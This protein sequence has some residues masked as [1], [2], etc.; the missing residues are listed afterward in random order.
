M[1]VLP[2]GK[3]IVPDVFWVHDLHT[4][5]SLIELTPLPFMESEYIKQIV[6]VSELRLY[7]FLILKPQS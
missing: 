1:K 5:P 2:F 3:F 7:T 4:F 6:N